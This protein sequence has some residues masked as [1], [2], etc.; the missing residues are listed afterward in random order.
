MTLLFATTNDHKFATAKHVCDKFGIEVR[1]KQL[2]IIEI[3]SDNG[4]E[5][6]THKVRDAYAQLQ[7]PVVVTDDSWLIKGL[8]GFPGPYM[9]Y[10]NQWLTADDFLRLTAGLSNRI[11]VLRHS[12]AYYDGGKPQVFSVDIE[13]VL[14]EEVRGSSKYPIFTIASFDGG[15]HSAAEVSAGGYTAI[16]EQHTAWHEL[17]EWLQK[18]ST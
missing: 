11:T 16:N 15:K 3:Q 9:K 8:N 2:D 7:E 4:E 10:M 1:R 6:A 13:C 12:V 17:C 18:R 14:L 5:I